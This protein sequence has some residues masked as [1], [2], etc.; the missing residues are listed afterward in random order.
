MKKYFFS[1]AALTIISAANGQSKLDK[2]RESIKDMTGCYKVTF[3]Y[4]E[5]FSPNADYEK[6]DNYSSWAYEYVKLIE[7]TPKHIKLQHL[8]IVNEDKDPMIIKHWRQDWD[9]ENTDFYVFEKR[10]NETGGEEWKYVSKTPEEVAGQWT[11]S[12]YQVDDSPR[13]DGSA[14]WVHYDGRNYWESEDAAPLPRREYSKRDDY[15]VLLRRNR[16]EIT[17]Y[18]WVHEQD[19]TKVLR[20]DGTDTVITHEKGWNTYEKV[21]AAQC[22]PAEKWWQENQDIWKKV[23]LEWDKK[24]AE[25]KDLKLWPKKGVKTMYKAFFKLDHSSTPSDI[26]A[27]ITEFSTKD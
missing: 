17:P 21:D 23:R 25:K 3:N 12:V 19:N 18:G 4:S 15:N 26:D 11:Q 27:I 14:T 10:N 1:L 7:D 6:Q 9:Y 5:T 8:L 13:Y 24:F 22:A 16:H 2:D 20:K